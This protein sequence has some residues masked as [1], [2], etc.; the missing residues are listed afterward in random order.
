MIDTRP[1]KLWK[2]AVLFWLGV[3][4]FLGWATATHAQ[5]ER[6]LAEALDDSLVTVLIRGRN[7]AFVEPMLEM[8]ISNQTAEELHLFLP[9]GLQLR[10]GNNAY[11]DVVLA[12]DETIVLAANEARQ[13]GLFAYSQEPDKAFPDAAVSYA[14]DEPIYRAEVMT[15]LDKIGQEGVEAD[16]ASQIALWMTL[17]N[18]TDFDA[19]ATEFGNGNDLTPYKKQTLTLLGLESGTAVSPYVLSG[20]IAVVGLLLALFFIFKREVNQSFDGYRLG[21]H[22]ASGGKYNV[23]QARRRGGAVDL[24]IKEPVDHA[25]EANCIREIEIREPLDEMPPNIVPL[26]G[27]GYYSPDKNSR[28]MP[29]L[30]E[31][32]IHGFDLGRVLQEVTKL[33]VDLALEIIAQLINGLDHLHTQHHIVHC[34][35]KPSN[36][37][38][39]REGRVWITD[40]GSASNSQTPDYTFVRREEANNSHW[41]APELIRRSQ[42]HYLANGQGARPT[43]QQ[44]IDHRTDLYSLGAI[45]YLLLLGEVPFDLKQARHFFEVLPPQ[46]DK[47][48]TFE[49]YIEQAIRRCLAPEPDD[50]FTTVADLRRSLNLPLPPS[51]SAQARAELGELVQTIAAELKR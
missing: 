42:A 2:T 50:R 48:V 1:T 18:A 24:I 10:S 4:L 17:A 9:A 32:Y 28:A 29:Y 51:Q 23:H 35:L 8:T 36:I 44:A 21:H 12:R 16:V 5:Q 30:V 7:I 45:L 38:L 37:L 25:T 27:S 22:V 20:S 41:H 13:M 6:P 49:P 43:S 3:S 15:L 31:R 39:D 11:A 33:E 14:L 47:L 19:F 40:F 46:L 34:D 26:F